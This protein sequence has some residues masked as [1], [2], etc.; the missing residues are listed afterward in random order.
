MTSYGFSGSG[1]TSVAMHLSPHCSDGARTSVLHISLTLFEV[2]PQPQKSYWSSG[3]CAGPYWRTVTAVI[4]L[5]VDKKS[6]LQK[7]AVNLC[8]MNP[9]W[10]VTEQQNANYAIR[11]G[12]TSRKSVENAQTSLNRTF[13]ESK[14]IW[15]KNDKT[16]R[17]G[18]VSIRNPHEMKVNWTMKNVVNKEFE[19]DEELWS[20]SN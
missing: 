10:N 1:A 6:V 3:V 19:H 15:E 14:V 5:I 4:K 12:L 2:M 18:C 17:I 11:S 20:I 13:K 7:Y 8:R 9:E 16:D